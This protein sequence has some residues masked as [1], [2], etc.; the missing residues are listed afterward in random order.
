MDITLAVDTTDTANL[1]AVKDFTKKLVTAIADSENAIHFSLMGY[2]ATPTTATNFRDFLSQQ[3]LHGLIDGLSGG[4]GEPRVDLALATLR[5][6]HFSL[7]GGMR[8]GHPRYVVLIS[9]GGNSA[10]SG[11]LDE[12]IQNLRELDV[13]IAAVGASG[14]V[15][16]AFLDQIATDKLVFKANAPAELPGLVQTMKNQLCNSKL[17]LFITKVHSKSTGVAIRVVTMMT[18]Q[19]LF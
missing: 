3:Q 12:G 15:N 13:K 11:P 4:G 5:K 10:S 17:L 7:E 19:P 8:Q 14:G 2:G 9:S 1:P 16:G 6:D 18:N